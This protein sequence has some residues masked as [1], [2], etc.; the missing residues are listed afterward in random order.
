M[1][2]RNIGTINPVD[3]GNGLSY[4]FLVAAD[5]M[6]FTL[7]HTIVRAGTQSRLKYDRHLEACYCIKGKG[8]VVEEDGTSHVI[9]ANTL[10]ALDQHDAHTLVAAPADDL[11][12][13]SVFNP[14][15]TGAEK[16]D[17]TNNGYSRY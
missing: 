15:L 11:H 10:Y 6:G 9:E 2:T 12:L 5:G 4:R 13:I 1:I 3:W 17:L 14:P 7:A 16:H 8:E